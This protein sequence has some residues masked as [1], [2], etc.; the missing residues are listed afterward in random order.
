ML[1]GVIVGCIRAVYIVMFMYMI[2]IT[3][4][5][6]DLQICKSNLLPM[7]IPFPSCRHSG[8][9]ELFTLKHRLFTITDIILE[10]VEV[11]VVNALLLS[12]SRPR[13]ILLCIL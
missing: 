4:L 6:A 10:H 12:C 2:C 9:A 1:C 7:F 13:S 11:K 3:A 8:T 5:Q